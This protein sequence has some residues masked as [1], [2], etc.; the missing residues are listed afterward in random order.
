MEAG[1]AGGAQP[2]L[3]DLERA[4]RAS[5]LRPDFE[6]ARSSGRRRRDA[7]ARFGGHH[8]RSRG[9]AVGLFRGQSALINVLAPEDD[10]HISN[11]GDYRRGL[12]VV[13]TPV[14]LHVA[15]GGGQGGGYP[16]SLLGYV[17]FIRQS[18]YDAQWQRDARAYADEQ[19]RAAA[20]IGA[21]ARRDAAGPR[22]SSRWRSR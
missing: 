2:T 11:I 18:F 1:H 5:I 4:K 9:A 10:P 22:E 7:A 13:K 16:G 20:G 8:E 3:E 17:A 21:G 14:A 6:A 15:F 19:G 12:V